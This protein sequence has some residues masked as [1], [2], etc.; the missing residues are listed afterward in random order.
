[1][2]NDFWH[3]VSTWFQGEEN[4]R[5]WRRMDEIFVVPTIL[6]VFSMV[7][8][9]FGFEDISMAFFISFIPAMFILMIWSLYVD[10]KQKRMKEL[11][12]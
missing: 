10:W 11:E 4:K 5:F 9:F 8:D 6:V 2:N 7:A 12:K 3:W 1:M